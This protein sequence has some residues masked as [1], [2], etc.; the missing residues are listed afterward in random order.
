MNAPMNLEDLLREQAD[1][2][3]FAPLPVESVMQRARRI[4]RRRT[5]GGMAGVVAAAAMLVGGTAV[6]LD[7]GR[8]DATPPIAHSPS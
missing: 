1:T 7:G 3:R 6:V 8:P 4:R 2:A 5:A